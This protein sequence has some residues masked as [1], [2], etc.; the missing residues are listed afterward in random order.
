M[1]VFI[2]LSLLLQKKREILCLQY[3]V[4]VT[5]AFKFQK[6]LIVLKKNTAQFKCL[7]CS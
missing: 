4:T 7:N 2:L 6:R 3:M 1:H 5:V